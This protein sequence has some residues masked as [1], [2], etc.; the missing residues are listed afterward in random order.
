MPEKNKS[1]L[2][3]K[4]MDAELKKGYD[5]FETASSNSQTSEESMGDSYQAM[6]NEPARTGSEPVQTTAAPEK[7]K[8]STLG[9]IWASLFKKEPPKGTKERLLSEEEIQQLDSDSS[10]KGGGYKPPEI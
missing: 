8:C 9:S 1:D 2:T 6:D 5:E 7:K 4:L 10:R 3:K